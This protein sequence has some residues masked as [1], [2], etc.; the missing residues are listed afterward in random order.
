MSITYE[1]FIGPYAQWFSPEPTGEDTQWEWPLI[2]SL[3]DGGTFYIQNNMGEFPQFARRG[4]EC[5]RYTLMP[6]RGRKGKP[7][8]P[9]RW[10]NLDEILNVLV[11]LTGVDQRA[12]ID[13]CRT[14]FAPELDRFR[15]FFGAAPAFGWGLVS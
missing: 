5:W 2:K 10:R 13:W 12:K 6:R 11:P 9:M 4:R 15:E 1:F 8:R 7:K 3:V 14:A